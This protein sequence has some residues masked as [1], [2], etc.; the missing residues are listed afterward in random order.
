MRKAHLDR[1][2]LEHR[3]PLPDNTLPRPNAISAK[4]LDQLLIENQQLG[5]NNEGKVHLLLAVGAMPRLDQ[6]YQPVFE[7]ILNEK[8]STVPVVGR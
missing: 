4:F 5:L 6:V 2:Q 8:I 1:L 3:V 7:R